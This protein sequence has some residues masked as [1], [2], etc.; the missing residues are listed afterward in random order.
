MAVNE[1]AGFDERNGRERAVRD[2]GVKV[3]RIL[4]VRLADCG[5]G[6]DRSIVLERVANVAVLVRSGDGLAQRIS[7]AYCAVVDLI[8]VSDVVVPLIAVV[9]PRDVGL[10][11]RIADAGYWRRWNREDG[12][13]F[14]GIGIGVVAVAEIAGV[15][16]VQQIVTAYL[17]S[18]T[19]RVRKRLQ[20]GDDCRN[21]RT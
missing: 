19:D 2:V 3:G 5:V 12:V 1:P 20:I 11:Q 7:R 14:A 15:V 9:L 17:A 10:D 21:A 6:H 16:V 4:D 13:E 18:G 8:W